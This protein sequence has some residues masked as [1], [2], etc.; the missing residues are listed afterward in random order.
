MLPT[1]Y[2]FGPYVIDGLLGAGGMGEVYRARD[3][4][5]DRTVAIK[6]L[7]P[8]LARDLEF[9]ERF[10]REARAV[11]ALNHPH[12]C[13]LYDVGADSSMNYLVMEYLEGQTLA[14]RLDEGPLALEEWV[15]VAGEFLSA[16]EAAHERQVVHRDIKPANIFITGR[17]LAKV[18]DFGVSKS[19]VSTGSSPAAATVAAT[20][21]IVGT[22]DYMS[23]EQ[24][25]GR[26][27][28]ARSDVFSAGIVLY[29]MAT[30]RHPF[31]GA[32]FIE[33]LHRTA[34]AEPPPIDR[35]SRGW[36][37]AEAIVRRCLR[38]VPA[39]RYA[40]AGVVLEDVR[41][42]QRSLQSGSLSPS[43]AETTLSP[44]STEARSGKRRHLAAGVI[45]VALLVAAVAAAAW[46]FST[47]RQPRSAEPAATGSPAVS[48]RR[49]VGVFGFRNLSRREADAWLSTALSE[50][51][52]AELGTAPALR[53]VAGENVARATSELLLNEET[54]LGPD[55]LSRVRTLL[56][57][58][59]VVLGSYLAVPASAGQLQV[60]ISLQDTRAGETMATLTAKGTTDDVLQ[61]V[62]ELGTQLRARLGVATEATSSSAVR[63]RMVTNSA[64]LRLYAEGIAHLRAQEYLLA[65]DT[66][67]KAVDADP[68]SAQLHAALAEAWSAL[69]YDARAR[70]EAALAADRAS[71]LGREERL[72][73]Q[74]RFHELTQQWEQAIED[75]RTLFGFFPDNVDYGVSLAIVLTRA[76]RPAEALAT[77]ASLRQ[78]P[79]PLREDV[80]I[81]LAEADAAH[82]I[83]DFTREFAAGRA[84]ADRGLAQG[85]RALVAQGRLAQAQARIRLGAPSDARQLLESARQLFH[86]AGDRS[87]EARALN[88]LANV[89]YEQ[90]DYSEAKRQF[91]EA[92]K[93]L[94]AVGNL[95]EL[96]G[97]L[98]NV[99][100]TMM[101]LD[102]LEPAERVFTDALGI[103]AERRDA[104]SE[105]FLRTNAGDLAYRR[106]RLTEAEA[107][108]R[109]GLELARGIG[110]PYAIYMALLALGNVSLARN[111]LSTAAARYEEG[112]ELARRTND[113]RYTAYL[114]SAL[115]NVAAARDQVE[116]ARRHHQEA[117]EIRRALG[118][119]AEVAESEIALALLALRAPPRGVPAGLDRA[120][121]DV[122]R[123]RLSS[124]E[125]L[126]RSVKAVLL[127]GA[128][129]TGDALRESQAAHLLLPKVQTVP[130]RLAIRILLARADATAGQRARAA[131]TLRSVAADAGRLGFV[132]L[133]RDAARSLADIT[134]GSAERTGGTAS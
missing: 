122:S 1:G 35:Q 12:V 134:A 61:I 60:N 87:G 71:G 115:G 133:E 13:T 104:V 101:M 112:L 98:N 14:A 99:A 76:G 24:A 93:I 44:F 3:T 84:A 126:A 55:T 59:V 28:D 46:V 64:A 58:D 105:A 38:K 7:S 77:I 94:R 43:A 56:G 67:A 108:G 125:C 81:D 4:R 82:A 68:G 113:R 32:D 5:L 17:G 39:E 51:L 19:L 89:A 49:A 123:L 130:W 40:S 107:S 50:M 127:G 52:S 6:V 110:N 88:R 36:S 21:G 20:G 37:E 47:A 18:L 106:G 92:E 114:L 116:E 26:P 102:E 15:R 119:R 41:R 10:E 66:L 78:L 118:G 45:G 9:R 33:T 11:A 63:S 29:E 69:G 131:T 57:A 74:S 48:A 120:I 80:R 65:R 96:A 30:A 23:P 100:D 85:A 70:E 16:L 128:G 97:V 132:R 109:K 31:R 42:L 91:Q 83:S 34:N 72:A 8:G 27:L 90:G 25:R 129:R 103:A 117:L 73:V 124:P 22:I 54:T 95:R 2:R 75:Y 86:A 121:E 79:S 53:V 111:D 62:S